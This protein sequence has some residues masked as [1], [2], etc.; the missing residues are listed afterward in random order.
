MGAKSPKIYRRKIC[1]AE[2]GTI[3]YISLPPK[4][5]PFFRE[6]EWCPFSQLYRNWG[7]FI[8]E[9][10]FLRQGFA[11]KWRWNHQA[12]SEFPRERLNSALFQK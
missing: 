7:S 8:G 9:A 3:Y 2:L 5:T 1:H 11:K 6:I 10:G 4:F 12:L